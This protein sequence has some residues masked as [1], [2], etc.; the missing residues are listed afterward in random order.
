MATILSALG[1][2]SAVAFAL[3]PQFSTI[4]P[5]VAAYCTLI[6][7]TVSAAS[8]ALIKFG[9]QNKLMTILGVALAVVS[10][11]AGAVDL[12]PANVVFALSVI[13]TVLAALGKSLFNWEDPPKPSDSGPTTAPFKAIAGFLLV[14]SLAGGFAACAKKIPGESPEA[15]KARA[16]AIRTAQGYVGFDLLQDTL[17]TLVDYDVIA[18]EKS[19]AYFGLHDNTLKSFD[20]I[21]E[22]LK[23]GLPVDPNDKQQVIARIDAVVVDLDKIVQALNVLPDEAA[24]AKAAQVV[25]TIRLTLS[26]IK[27]IIAAQQMGASQGVDAPKSRAA[28]NELTT[29]KGPQPG[30]WNVL[31]SLIADKTAQMLVISTYVDPVAAWDEAE[32]LSA[33]MHAENANRN[34]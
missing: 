21:K 6:G 2:L 12:L 14:G 5:R 26:S 27:V 33:A 24:K 17:I 9:G 18:D 13:G 31:I 23:S 34:P 30:W 11:A 7:T 10:V 22:R 19:A 25:G 1:I 20:V 4:N 32:R 8:G 16:V 3:A 28:Y 29:L 15:Y